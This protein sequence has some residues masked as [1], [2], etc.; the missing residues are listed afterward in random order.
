MTGRP[1]KAESSSKEGILST[2][3]ADYPYICATEARDDEQSY[4]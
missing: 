3:T 1:R 2:T 4:T